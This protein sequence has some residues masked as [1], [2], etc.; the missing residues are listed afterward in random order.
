[1]KP[2]DV[3]PCSTSFGNSCAVFWAA[4]LY[5]PAILTQTGWCPS[6]VGPKGAVAR[7]S[8]SQTKTPISTFRQESNKIACDCFSIEKLFSVPL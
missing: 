6:A 1:M 4:S 7:Q 5:H 8:L 2:A 3:I